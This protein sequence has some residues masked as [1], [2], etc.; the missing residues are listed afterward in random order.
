MESKTCQDRFLE[1]KALKGRNQIAPGSRP[2]I[3]I[4]LKQSPE[5]A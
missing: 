3:R 4:A 5:G 2:G 1:Q